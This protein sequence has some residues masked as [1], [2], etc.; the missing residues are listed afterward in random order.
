MDPKLQQAIVET[1]AGNTETAQRLLAATLQDNPQEAEAWFLL[2]HLVETPERQARYLEYALTLQPDHPLASKHLSRLLQPDVPPPVIKSGTSI[3]SSGRHPTPAPEI[4]SEFSPIPPAR[5][6]AMPASSNPSH[7]SSSQ[8][9]VAAASSAT[10]SSVNSGVNTR[11]VPVQDSK[12]FD[13]EW[14][15]TAGSPQR[16]RQS[17]TPVVRAVRESKP[18]A[19]APPA[20]AAPQT[21]P[22]VESTSTNKWLVAILIALV[23]VLFFAA[24]FLAYT[25]FFQ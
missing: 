14:S 25:F 17:E 10:S 21:V 15:R 11:V 9:A 5:T 19:A 23:V 13:P 22:E 8:S 4:D 1:R 20:P 24:S 6:A 18:S 2:A 7:T 16:E 12:R 3:A